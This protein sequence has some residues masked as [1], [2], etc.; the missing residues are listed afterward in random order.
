M[1]ILENLKELNLNEMGFEEYYSREENVYLKLYDHSISIVD[2][3]FALKRGM[4]VEKIIIYQSNYDEHRNFLYDLKKI[5]DK[6][7]D[8]LEFTKKVL[9]DPG[10]LLEIENFGM[11]FTK[12]NTKGVRVYSPF[13]NQKD[14]KVPKKWKVSDIAKGILSGQITNG[15]KNGQY[16][17][18]YFHDYSVNYNKGKL[19]LNSFCKELIESPSGW[20]CYCQEEKDQVFK[21][22][23]NCY[24]FNNNTVYFNLNKDKNIPIDEVSSKSID[25]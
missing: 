13:Y 25:S 18:D 10:T 6:Y 15:I 23:I 9:G 19:D 16:S 8:V 17:D 3:T 22:S 7:G 4:D 12:S 14:I 21:I 20:W 24:N 2:L 5:V 11:S 1:K